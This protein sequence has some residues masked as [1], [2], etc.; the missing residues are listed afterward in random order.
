MRRGSLSL[1]W[2]LLVVLAQLPAEGS[3]PDAGVWDGPGAAA[4]EQTVSSG[5]AAQ[6]KPYLEKTILR[7][8]DA[9]ANDQAG[10]SVAVSG[11]IAIVTSRGED[12]GPGDPAADAGAAYIFQRNHGGAQRW[13]EV[14]KLTA[15]D[16]QAGDWFGYSVAISG[17]TA[18]VGA[19]KED[20]GPG[21]PL[22]DAGAAYVFQRN[23]DGADNW[24]EVAKLTA[25]DAQ[26]YDCFGCTVAISGDTVIVGAFAK[27]GGSGGALTMA[28]AAYVFQ[29]DQGGADMWGEVAKLTASV[30]QD[31]GAFGVSVSI[32]G[33]TA[34]IGALFTNGGP[35]DSVS[36]AGAAYVYQWDTGGTGSWT[37]VKKLTA[38]DAQTGDQFGR[39]VTVSGDTVVVAAPFENGGPGDPVSEAGAAYVFQRNAGGVDSWGE[40]KKLTASDIQ[41]GDQFGDVSLDG[42]TLAIGTGREDGGPGSPINRAGAVY[43]FRR[44]L[45]GADNWGQMAKLMASDA[46]ENDWFGDRV[47]I[48]GTTILAAAT[49]EDGGPGD[50]LDMAGTAYLFVRNPVTFFNAAWEGVTPGQDLARPRFQTGRGR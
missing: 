34:I 39:F 21:D 33:D 48:S 14:K 46:Q 45:G 37:E 30:P 32:A 15:S 43:V 41:G 4:D 10:Y 35:A 22:A 1:G 26:A 28:G 23:K 6:H 24:G 25:S 29:R 7:A 12:G 2:V 20:G 18:V 3:L 27:A 16:T 40:V 49:S 42:D 36:Q 38:S 8:S 44:D 50:P 11:D 47:S 9:Q 5:S 13:G 31:S 17:D 19:R